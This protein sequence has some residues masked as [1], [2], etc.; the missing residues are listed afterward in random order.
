MKR[1]SS[2]PPRDDDTDPRRI[3]EYIADRDLVDAFQTAIRS[4][5][6]GL[7]EAKS[8]LLGYVESDVG[9]GNFAW[10]V[11]ETVVRASGAEG[12]RYDW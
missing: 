8:G 1:M 10:A 9:P 7:E 4:R 5:Q 11:M 3:A 6:L 12:W 2:T